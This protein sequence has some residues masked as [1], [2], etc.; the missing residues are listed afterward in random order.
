MR[1]AK[2][3]QNQGIGQIVSGSHQTVYPSHEGNSV[4]KIYTEI[5]RSL[6]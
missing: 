4:E 2:T 1:S 3:R 5:A 6:P